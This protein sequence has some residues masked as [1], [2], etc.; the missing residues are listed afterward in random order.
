MID[1]KGTLTWPLEH[2]LRL[3]E[4]HFYLRPKGI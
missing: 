1:K 3:I 2:E 4:R